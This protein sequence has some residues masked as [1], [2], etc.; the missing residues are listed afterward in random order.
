MLDG[1]SLQIE[2]GERIGLLGR[3]GSGKSTLMK[4]L[5]GDIIPDR[6]E[7]VRD[8]N[9]RISIMPQ[10]VED[11]PGS[12][13][14]VVA[15]GGQKHLDLLR[16]YHDLIIQ[17]TNSRDQALLEKI[18]RVQHQLEAVD[19]WQFHQK[20]EAVISRVGLDE[21]AEIR[22]LSAG[23]ERRV[24]LA[25]ALTADPDILLLDEPTHHLDITSILWL[26][27]FLQSFDKTLM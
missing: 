13:Y 2:A 6:G 27:E 16:S 24:L 21:N 1:A 18:E 3:N 5:H 22:F 15:S 25:R 11:I 8:K 12:V 9:V 23:L 10:N 20:V 19:A 17:M 14:D 26:E 4:L 7:I